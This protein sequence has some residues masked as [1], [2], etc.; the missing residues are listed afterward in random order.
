MNN[1]KKSSIRLFQNILIVIFFFS[2]QLYG[3]GFIAGTLIK[4]KNDY[5]PIEKLKEKDKIL[6]YNYKTRLIVESGILKI[7]KNHSEKAIRIFVDGAEII[8]TPDHKF[9]CPLR[10]GNWIEA[11]DLQQND[12]ILRNICNLVRIEK[13]EPF[14]CK[15]DLYCLSINENHNFFVSQKDIFVHNIE[16]ISTTILGYEFVFEIALP[17][18]IAAGVYLF[19]KGKDSN[20]PKISSISGPNP[21]LDPNDPEFKKFPS[22]NQLKQCVFKGKAPNDIIRADK[23][24]SNPNL[25]H[26]HFPDNSAINRNGTFRDGNPSKWL[27]NIIKEFLRSFGWKV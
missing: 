4:T 23:H 16:I 26:V 6:S 22:I 12:F 24:P 14:E 17:A 27:T 20:L 3:N 9:F 5:V 10:K 15:S 7:Q 2:C 18:I 11:K 25:D 1:I 8:T 13:V 19:G 21:S